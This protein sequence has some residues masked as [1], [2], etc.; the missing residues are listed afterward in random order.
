MN[1]M[2]QRECEWLPQLGSSLGKLDTLRHWRYGWVN[3]NLRQGGRDWGGSGL[4]TTELWGNKTGKLLYNVQACI[5]DVQC[6]VRIIVAAPSSTGSP[7]RL[8]ANLHW[9]EIWIGRG[10]IRTSPAD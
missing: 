9:E 5:R 3:L 10:L 8:A 4:E 7:S 2:L 6:I 1:L